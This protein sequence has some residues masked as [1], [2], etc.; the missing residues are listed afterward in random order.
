MADVNAQ[1]YRGDTPLHVG[2]RPALFGDRSIE[3]PQIA[4]LLLEHGADPYIPDNTGETPAFLIERALDTCQRD[5]SRGAEADLW[6]KALDLCG[7]GVG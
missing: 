1:T 2:I 4:I 3:R 7:A 5:P 6:Q